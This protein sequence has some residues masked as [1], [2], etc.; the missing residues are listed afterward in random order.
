MDKEKFQSAL[1]Y[2]YLCQYCSDRD[3]VW[4]NKAT[5]Y[6]NYNKLLAKFLIKYYMIKTRPS[7]YKE[8]NYFI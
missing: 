4:L 6:L 2:I 8:S 1:G 5:Q 7:K 3:N